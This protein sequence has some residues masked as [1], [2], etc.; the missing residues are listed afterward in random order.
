MYTCIYIYIHINIHITYSICTLYLS[1]WPDK[2]SHPQES[3]T[4]LMLLTLLEHGTAK[5][6]GVSSIII[7]GQPDLGCTDDMYIYI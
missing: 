2:A 7:T 4:E 3:P 1:V 5:E 6:R